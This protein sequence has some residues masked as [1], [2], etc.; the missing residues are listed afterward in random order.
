MGSLSPPI[1][2][3]KGIIAISPESGAIMHWSFTKRITD[4]V[5]DHGGVQSCRKRFK[6]HLQSNAFYISGKGYDWR[7]RGAVGDVFDV[8]TFRLIED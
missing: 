4:T 2:G 8:P 3:L 5:E 6:E 7:E 1:P